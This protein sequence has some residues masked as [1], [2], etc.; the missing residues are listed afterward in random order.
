MSLM[1]IEKKSNFYYYLNIVIGFL[2]I[3]GF[4]YLQPI[5]PLTRAGMKISGIFI[6]TIFL[7]STSGV[8]WPSIAGILALGT[9]GYMSM[10]AAIAAGVGSSV[11]FQLILIMAVSSGLTISGAGE[12]LARWSIS[13]PFFRGK[14]ELFVF[15]F[16]YTFCLISIFI[17]SIAS[18]FL[19][20][21]IYYDIAD[22]IGYKKGDRFSTMFIIGSLLGPMLGGA[23]IPFRGWQLGLIIA[24][25]TA[26][27]T[28]VRYTLFMALGLIISTIILVLYVGGMKYLFRCDFEK[29]RTFDMETLIGSE[30]RKLDKRQKALFGAYAVILILALI[31]TILPSGLWV[32]RLLNK[33]LTSTEI[34]GFAAIILCLIKLDDGK[35]ILDFKA[36]A[37]KGVSWEVILLCASAIP[38][39]TALT[40]KETGVLAL[41]VDILGPLFR[42][43]SSGSFLVFVI[44]CVLV[45]TNLGSNLGMGMLMIPI[46]VPFIGTT[47][48]NPV[49]VGIALIFVTNMGLMLPGASA[50]AAILYGNDWVN[51][52]EIIKYCGFCCLLILLV[53]VPVFLLCNLLI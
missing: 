11:V 25:N 15:A 32:S 44:L 28:S 24:F 40:S 42:S 19:A 9:S 46:M 29:L 13:R 21:T 51:P 1:T 47:G 27:G 12:Y 37:S 16:F 30:T 33:S 39:A 38:I 41:S 20:W 45:L 53:T 35:P 6:G 4:G 48:A 34:F 3:F 2:F 26:A 36:A 49:L 14:P 17:S 5:E 10:E 7:W 8:I 18:I 31:Q 22:M 52:R 23:T 43:M 50:L